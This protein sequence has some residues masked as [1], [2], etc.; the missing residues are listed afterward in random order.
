MAFFTLDNIEC[1]FVSFPRFCLN[2]L[3]FCL[4]LQRFLLTLWDFGD[5]VELCCF[6][7]GS[8][9]SLVFSIGLI[10]VSRHKSGD[11]MNL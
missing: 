7:S 6:F 5:F 3:L 1:I 8:V 10:G 11:E 9:Y 2:C 4:C